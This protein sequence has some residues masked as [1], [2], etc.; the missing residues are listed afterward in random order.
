MSRNLTTEQLAHEWRV[1]SEQYPAELRKDVLGTV[2]EQREHL[3][4]VFY[5]RML[6][7]PA[8]SFF[9][10]DD[11][12]RTR[13]RQAMQGWLQQ[14][15]ELGA[16]AEGDFVA[17][18]ERQRK[19][20]EAHA[21][22]GIPA[23]AVMR[24]LRSIDAAV[25]AVYSRRQA[26]AAMEVAAYVSQMTSMAIEIMCQTYAISHDRNARA[27]ESYRLF[28]MS[29][30]IGAEKERQRA[31]LLD[32]ENQLMYALSMRISSSAALGLD[33]DTVE[34]HCR[35][36]LPELG[37]SEFGLW[38]AHKAAHIFEGAP[39]VSAIHKELVEIDRMLVRDPVSGQTD[40]AYL[41]Q[42]MAEVRQKT[43]LVAFLLDELFQQAGHMESGRDPLTRL[44]NRR[45]LQV[46]LTRQIDQARRQNSQLSVLTI[47]IDHFKQV[48]DSHGHDAGD[49]ALQQVS[50]ILSSALRGGD[51]IFR[52]G[53]EEFLVLLVEA[54]LDQSM[55]I[56]EDIRR[57]IADANLQLPN[58]STL[59]TT[60][61]IGVASHDG[62]PDYQ[63]LLK[64]SDQAL[65]QAKN[66]GRN[67]VV[68]Y[69]PGPGSPYISAD[70]ARGVAL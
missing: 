49:M 65:Y 34:V 62:H 47:D 15:F 7:D 40:T 8:C 54:D 26:P 22:I 60:L 45:Y 46:I 53:G 24:G 57:Q 48:N 32:W 30:D 31:A 20:G 1:I 55:A 3:V 11:L 51:Y 19:V 29:Q 69:L 10:S 63:R 42:L 13:L 64:H 61:S 36:L 67:R 66:A 44:L 2:M 25:Y 9:L 18:V 39:D 4:T 27:E 12:V 37:K 50:Q 33:S 14:V 59:S 58:G 56:A 68:G 70:R 6:L 43:K 17:A 52:L 5:D 35:P 41:A 21:R 23:Y 38:F 28:A 16:G